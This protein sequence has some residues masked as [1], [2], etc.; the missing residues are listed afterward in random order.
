M[1]DVEMAINLLART[2]GA[3]YITCSEILRPIDID[4][5]S[6]TLPEHLVH[7]LIVPAWYVGLGKRDNFQSS[8][9]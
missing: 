8:Y 7:A 6:L 3:N 5:I 1:L 4:V 2:Q 9:I